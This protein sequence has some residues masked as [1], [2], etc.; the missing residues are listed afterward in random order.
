MQ[1]GAL[2]VPGSIKVCL[3]ASWPHSA[4]RNARLWDEG[5]AAYTAAKARLE[6]G[7]G[8]GRAEREL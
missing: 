4:A 3:M 8:R 5:M 2:K 6:R 7:G 1:G